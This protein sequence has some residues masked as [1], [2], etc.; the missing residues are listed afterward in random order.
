M[1]DYRKL[2]PVRTYI[3]QRNGRMEIVS[4]HFRSYPKR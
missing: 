4:K 3:R 2:V 1:C